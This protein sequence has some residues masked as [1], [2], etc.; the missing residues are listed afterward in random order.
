[1]ATNDANKEAIV[2][3]GGVSAL[4]A[5]L[6]PEFNEDERQAAAEALWKLSF[7]DSNKAVILTHVTYTDEEALEGRDF[8]FIKNGY[9][10]PITT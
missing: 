10:I 7:L 5:I 1:M 3:H 9:K 8:D 2:Q 6:R 4:A